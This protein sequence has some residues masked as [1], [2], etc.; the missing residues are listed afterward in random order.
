M[1]II[2]AKTPSVNPTSRSVE[3][4]LSFITLGS[5]K[6][7]GIPFPLIRPALL[8]LKIGFFEKGAKGLVCEFVAVLSMDGFVSREMK[9]KVGWRDAHALIALAFK[10]HLDA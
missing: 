10:M 6:G 1:V 9:V 5:C 8:H 2:T 3:V 7:N 4:L